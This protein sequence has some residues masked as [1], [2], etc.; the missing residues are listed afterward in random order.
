MMV[1]FA[2]TRT[3]LYADK[4]KV[5]WLALTVRAVSLNELSFAEFNSTKFNCD[6]SILIE[7]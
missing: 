1:L 3:L 4:L 6:S 5:E 2:L 7:P